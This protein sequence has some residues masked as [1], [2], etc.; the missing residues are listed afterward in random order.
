MDSDERTVEL[1]ASPETNAGMGKPMLELFVVV[2]L[3]WVIT[4]RK[5]HRNLLPQSYF[6]T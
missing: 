2:K 3:E 5:V 4:R 1:L 6:Q